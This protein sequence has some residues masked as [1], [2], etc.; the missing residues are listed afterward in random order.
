MMIARS[1]AWLVT[2]LALLAPPAQAQGPSH[3]LDPLTAPEYWAAYDGIR[4]SGRTDDKTR[5]TTVR[6]NPPPKA[7]VLAWRPGQT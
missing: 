2:A 7:E 5:F 3:P 4:A 1:K 6:L